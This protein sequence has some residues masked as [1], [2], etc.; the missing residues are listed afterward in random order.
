MNLT[1]GTLSRALVPAPSNSQ[2]APCC[3]EDGSGSWFQNPAGPG[4]MEIRVENDPDQ[5]SP[6]LLVGPREGGV[7]E[8]ASVS[9]R[10]EGTQS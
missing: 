4:Y 8:E 7:T 6:D 2:L 3:G 1:L 9:W 5:V 10:G